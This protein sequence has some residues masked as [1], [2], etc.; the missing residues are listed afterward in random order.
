V[1]LPSAIVPDYPWGKTEEEYEELWIKGLERD[2][3]GPYNLDS[4]APSAANDEAA[5]PLGP[6]V[7]TV[8]DERRRTLG[9]GCGK[10]E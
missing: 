2:W 4:G 7:T 9:M 5:R 10:H 3:G 8:E 1:P 6:G